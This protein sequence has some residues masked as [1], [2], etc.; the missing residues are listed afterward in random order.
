[1]VRA[2]YWHTGI[3]RLVKSQRQNRKRLDTNRASKTSIR[4]N[5]SIRVIFL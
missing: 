5:A 1:M 3:G 2:K 4:V